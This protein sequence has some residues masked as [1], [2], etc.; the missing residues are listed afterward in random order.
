M[1]GAEQIRP[2]S[3]VIDGFRWFRRVPYG[4]ADGLK[5]VVERSQVETV[6]TFKPTSLLPLVEEHVAQ[7][8]QTQSQEVIC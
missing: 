8:F 6:K 4:C 2:G 1:S 7:K 3:L 5:R